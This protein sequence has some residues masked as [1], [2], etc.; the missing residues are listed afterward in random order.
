[1]A[2]HITV[3]RPILH[4]VNSLHLGAFCHSLGVRPR[5]R[6]GSAPNLGT[7]C[8][9]TLSAWF[10]HLL[11]RPPCLGQCQGSGYLPICDVEV[12]FWMFDRNNHELS[13]MAL[14]S[15]VFWPSCNYFG[16]CD[17]AWD[18]NGNSTDGLTVMLPLFWSIGF[19]LRIWSSAWGRR[20][21]HNEDNIEYYSSLPNTRQPYHYSLW[22]PVWDS[23]ELKKSSAYGTKQSFIW[24]QSRLMAIHI[25]V[26]RPILIELILNNSVV[27][28]DLVDL[29]FLGKSCIF[30]SLWDFYS[31]PW[32]IFYSIHPS[33][34]F[35]WFIIAQQFI[36][37]SW[38]KSVAYGTKTS[39]VGSQSRLMAISTYTS[40][41]HDQFSSSSH[42]VNS[43]QFSRQAQ[44]CWLA[45]LGQV[46]SLLLSVG[47]LTL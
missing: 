14:F 6:P 44:S 27:M 16:L 3:S 41:S 7:F 26:S 8:Q 24:S 47:L 37:S 35:I 1:M 31:P 25:T 34:T 10:G 9:M 18:G 12:C 20:G 45:F 11:S 13:W 28:H 22:V 42:R 4:R 23:S 15:L 40:R 30:S 21:S 2:I 36:H 33:R 19:G 29:P 43:Q 32:E 5:S 39:F 46:T 17:R 38:R